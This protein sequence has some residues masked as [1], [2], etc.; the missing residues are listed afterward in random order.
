MSDIKGSKTNL[1]A[2]KGSKEDIKGSTGNLA[3]SKKKSLSRTLAG[4]K[5]NLAGSKGN[6]AGSKANLS[7]TSTQGSKTNVAD[8][9][10]AITFENTYQLKPEKKFPTLLAREICQAVL[11]KHLT[12][13]KYDFELVPQLTTAIANEIIAEAKK[14]DCPRYKIVVDVNVGEFKGQGIKVA[15]RAVWDTTTDTYAS[16]SFKNATLFAVAMIFGC[17]YE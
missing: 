7:K 10:R 14:L 13:V 1:A 6:L 3:D 16:A 8:N 11:N 4:S 5:G 17:Y 9:A 2:V 12:K 15:S